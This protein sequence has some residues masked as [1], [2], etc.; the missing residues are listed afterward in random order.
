MSIT[1]SKCN[2]ELFGFYCQE[3][4]KDHEMPHFE[5]MLDEYGNKTQV[6][7]VRECEE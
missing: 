6:T 7:W 5:F 3:E 2:D 4:G 1:D